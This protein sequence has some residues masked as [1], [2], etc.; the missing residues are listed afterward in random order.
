MGAWEYG[1]YDNDTALDFVG[2]LE[3]FF[4]EKLNGSKE[5]EEIRVIADIAQHL[6]LEILPNCVEELEFLLDDEDWINTWN[7]PDRIKGMIQEEIKKCN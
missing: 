6:D 3:S 5:P 1:I 2:D 7:D 4:I